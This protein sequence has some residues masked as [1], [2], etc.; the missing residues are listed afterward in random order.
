MDDYVALGL[1]AVL[2]LVVSIVVWWVQF[3]LITPDLRFSKSISKRVE[4]GHPTYRFK[5]DNASRRRGIIDLSLDV[6]VFFPKVGGTV[7]LHLFTAV[8][9]KIMRVAPK[10]NRV[11]RLDLREANWKLAHPGLL[12]AVGVSPTRDRH[13]DLET[14]LANEMAYLRIRIL[15]Y[16]ELSGSRKFFE[17]GE[18]R[19]DDIA[20]EA[21]TGVDV[22]DL[23]AGAQGGTA[24]DA[25]ER[26][27]Y[28][29][30][31]TRDVERARAFYGETLGLAASSTTPDEFETANVTLALW[32]PESDGETFAP[33]PAGIALAVP[34]VEAARARLASEGVELIGDTV[35]T[36]VCHMAFILDPDGNVLILHHRYEP[37]A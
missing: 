11:V 4:H 29:S 21:V 9:D 37:K 20:E 31:P 25:I 28:V 22:D 16:D 34:D 23:M 1:G 3:R 7:S 35:D 15:A 17:S 6:R 12:Q 10:G 19:L 33:N 8:G 27:D 14:L 18:Y 32:Q 36:G 13:V 24:L 30:V 2:G 26:V 5:I